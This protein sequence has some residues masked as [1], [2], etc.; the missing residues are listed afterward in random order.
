MKVLVT[1][2]A[3]F[4]GSAI[5]IRLLNSNYEVL[6]ID[7]LNNYYSTRLKKDRLNLIQK[8]SKSR[9]FQFIEADIRDQRIFSSITVPDIIIHLAAEVGVRN[10]LIKPRQYLETNIN[11]FFE[12]LEFAKREKI[13]NFIFASTSSVYGKNE[14]SNTK[15]TNTTDSPLQIYSVTKKVNELMAYAYNNL[16]DINTIGLRFF[17]VYGP[18]GRPDMAIYEFTR[19]IIAGESI[20]LFNNG[21]YFRS[22][23]F[24]DD[25]TYI[26]EKMINKTLDLNAKPQYNIFNVGNPKSISTGEVIDIMEKIIGKK[27]KLNF[28]GKKKT[29]MEVT[30][31]NIEHLTNYIGDLSFTDFTSGYREFY[32]WFQRY[33]NE[34]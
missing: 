33:Q 32:S 11:G 2:A 25:V 8:I 15:E 22:F 24:V 19:R 16:F 31:A 9:A 17:T 3:G 14:S 13:K 10:S 23:T 1:G 21:N 26:I 29:E 27:A 6:G 30:K 34:K 28:T 12:I 18:M 7:N 5:C 4:I 20:D